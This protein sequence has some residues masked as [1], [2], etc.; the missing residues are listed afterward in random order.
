MYLNGLY[1]DIR[2][3]SIFRNIFFFIQWV[4]T[5]NPLSNLV[6]GIYPASTETV[7]DYD[8]QD[9]YCDPRTSGSCTHRY[10]VAG[11]YYFTS[12]SLVEDFAFGGK[13]IVKH[14]DDFHTSIVVFAK[15][16]LTCLL[17]PTPELTK[18]KL[19]TFKHAR[20]TTSI[21]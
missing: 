10:D 7:T 1:N 16:I 21:K 4:W 8:P 3:T 9:S 15:G 19:L 13:V 18:R 12:G 11:V 5:T 20:D 6:I 14:K 17:Y 2:C